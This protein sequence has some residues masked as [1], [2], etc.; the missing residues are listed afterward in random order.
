[1]ISSYTPLDADH[2]PSEVIFLLILLLL[3]FHLVDIITI[4]LICSFLRQIPIV[5]GYLHDSPNDTSE[6]RG[7]SV[8]VD[9]HTVEHTCPESEHD[10]PID[11]EAVHTDLPSSADD[12]CDTEG[13]V[14]DDDADRDAFVNAAVEETRASPVKRSTG[15]F[16]DEDDLFDM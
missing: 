8:P 5:S 7:S 6:G 2:P 15:G 9:F 11:S 14:R 13:S 3:C 1:L 12:A 16:A 10:D 4:V